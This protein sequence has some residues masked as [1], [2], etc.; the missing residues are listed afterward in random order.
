MREDG[1]LC[2]RYIQRDYE[3]VVI[4]ATDPGIPSTDT[5]MHSVRTICNQNPLA[6]EHVKW[7]TGTPERSRLK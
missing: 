1:R 7:N 4:L 2:R 6:P 3:L 5:Y